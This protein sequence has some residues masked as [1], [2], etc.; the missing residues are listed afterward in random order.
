MDRYSVSTLLL[1]IGVVAAV[2]EVPSIDDVRVIN[3]NVISFKSPFT[4]GGLEGKDSG[5]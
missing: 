4:A 5:E 2:A 3:E 1:L